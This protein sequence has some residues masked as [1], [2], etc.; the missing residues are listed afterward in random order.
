MHT[1]TFHRTEYQL[2]QSDP[3]AK[4]LDRVFTFSPSLDCTIIC[5]HLYTRYLANL[6]KSFLS[7][8]LNFA[9]A[10]SNKM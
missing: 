2:T 9:V 6:S 7:C 5:I 3:V 10:I 1:D 8:M 4:A